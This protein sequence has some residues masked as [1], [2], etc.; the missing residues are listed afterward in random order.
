[1]LQGAVVLFVL[2]LEDPE[3]DHGR[4]AHLVER[5]LDTLEAVGSKPTAP[6]KSVYAEGRVRI[7]YGP[8]GP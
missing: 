2:C 1:M 3:E 5:Q 8:I 6:T 4:V 7:P